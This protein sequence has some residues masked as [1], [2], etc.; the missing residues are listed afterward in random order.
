MTFEDYLKQIIP[1]IDDV[2]VQGIAK[3]A[4]AHGFNNLTN[5][6]KYTLE[7]G[8]SDFIMKDCPNCGEEISYEDMAIAIENGHCSYCEHKWQKM[9]SE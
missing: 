9:Q 2:K 6:Q 3:L 1:N 4:A 8:I 5:A 7:T